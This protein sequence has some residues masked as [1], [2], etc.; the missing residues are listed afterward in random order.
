MQTISR[1]AF[2]QWAAERGI[3]SDPRYPRFESLIFNDDP[4]DFRYWEYPQAASEAPHF[5]NAMV[6]AMGVD[7]RYWLYPGRGC[8]SLGHDA[9]S[10]PQSKIWK[11]L[12]QSIGVP[13]G[14][15]GAVCVEPEERDVFFAL[16]FLQVM[17]GPSVHID[18]LVVPEAGDALLFFEHHKVVHMRFLNPAR[19]RGV[20]SAME[21]AG[22]SLPLEPPDGT[23]KPIPWV[24]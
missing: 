17:L 3:S 19:L 23:F 20:I 24:K 5:I 14:F 13:D 10:W 16:L 15:I 18:M 8:W 7:Q 22:Y 21:G 4:G 12:L 9:D 11:T 1:S 2:L 6:K